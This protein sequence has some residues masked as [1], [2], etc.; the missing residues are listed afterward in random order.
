MDST[1]VG[2]VEN[3]IRDGAGIECVAAEAQIHKSSCGGEVGK[4][5]PKQVVVKIK[6]D[7][8]EIGKEQRERLR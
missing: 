1:K 6:S 8:V 2:Q 7:C 5:P 3:I 4:T